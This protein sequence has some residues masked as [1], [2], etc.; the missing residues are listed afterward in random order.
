M[1]NSVERLNQT[2]L[3]IFF[4]ID[5]FEKKFPALRVGTTLSYKTAIKNN[6]NYV[7]VKIIE[8]TKGLN[9]GKITQAKICPILTFNK[10]QI[11]YIPIA[12]DISLDLKTGWNFK[13]CKFQYGKFEY[14]IIKKI[15]PKYEYLDIVSTEYQVLD[16]C[17]ITKIPKFQVGN[18]FVFVFNQSKKRKC[19]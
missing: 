19:M 14:D 3:D 5:G 9:I 1:E 6:E 13:N 2:K 12:K 4:T 15:L 7:V 10:K 11:E 18:V 17:I 8:E 16:N